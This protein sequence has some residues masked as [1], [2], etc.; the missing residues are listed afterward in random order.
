MKKLICASVLLAVLCLPTLAE[1]NQQKLNIL[2]QRIKDLV[3]NYPEKVGVYV[4]DLG[5]GQEYGYNAD[6]KFPTASVAKIAVMAAAYHLAESGKINLNS[7]IKFRSSDKL[8]GSGVLQWLS[9]G[10]AYT[11]WNLIRM[12]IVLSDNTATRMVANYIGLVQINDYCAM[13]QMTNTII[14]D[15]TM[16]N[17]FP[18]EPRNFTSPKD[19]AQLTARLKDAK[20]FSAQS[21]KEMLGFMKNQKYRWG[22]WRGVPKGTVVANKT[23]NLEGVLNDVGIIYTNKGNFVISVFTNGFGQKSNARKMINKIT[24]HAYCLYLAKSLNTKF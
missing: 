2:D 19:M 3:A 4:I 24:Q 1:F 10:Q 17:E 14:L 12:M 6:K 18:Q 13:M 23:G 7:K 22:I 9:P 15:P 20:Y 16:L 5:N 11:L 21:S 8:G